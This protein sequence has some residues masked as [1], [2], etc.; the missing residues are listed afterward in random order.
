MKS[1]L[2]EHPAACEETPA[3]IDHIIERYHQTHRREMPDLVALARK[4]EKVHG[5]DPNAPHGLADALQDMIGEMEIH[6][7]KEELLL[8]PALARGRSRTVSGPV[9]EPIAA[10]RHDHDGQEAALTRIAA[11]T[12]G[13]RLPS[14]ACKSWQRLYAGTRKLVDDVEEHIY[15]ENEILFPRFEGE[16]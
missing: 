7:K 8:F 1:N 12:H 3:L 14:D 11:I 6:M 2:V 16:A 15:L 13:F 10:M 5:T 9:G 4:V